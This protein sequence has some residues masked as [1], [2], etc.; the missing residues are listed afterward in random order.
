MMFVK[1]E[2]SIL[3]RNGMNKIH[4]ILTRV[5]SYRTYQEEGNLT[6]EVRK[7]ID[8]ILET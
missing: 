2:E 1:N 5:C 8:D 3:N 7:L 6:D 4:K